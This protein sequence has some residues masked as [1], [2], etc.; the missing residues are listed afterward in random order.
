MSTTRSNVTGLWYATD[1]NGTYI[2]PGYHT[3]AAAEAEA[4][5]LT[6]QRQP[7]QYTVADLAASA[8]AA[9]ASW[10]STSYDAIHAIFADKGDAERWL[11]AHRTTHAQPRYLLTEHAAL[12]LDYG[13]TWVDRNGHG[14]HLGTFRPTHVGSRAKYARNSR[15]V[16][17]SYPERGQDRG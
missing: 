15:P 6:R 16:P 2:T 9:G 8:V 3:Q 12:A 4:E 14:V 11:Q 13:N 10:L 5:R 1:T 17:V 7:E